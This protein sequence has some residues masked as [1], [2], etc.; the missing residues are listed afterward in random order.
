MEKLD[1]LFIAIF[2]RYRR[3][4]GDASIEQAWRRAL[5]SATGY[6]IFPVAVPVVLLMALVNASLQIG[7]HSEHRKVVQIVA[8]VIGISIIY[9]MERRFRRFLTAPPKLAVQES[10][11]ERN[12][13]WLARLSSAVCLIAIGAL[14]Y[15]IRHSGSH[16]LDGY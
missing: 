4:M 3:K 11:P 13:I 10:I 7:T 2:S 15:A 14:G 16:F 8:V 9:G 6:F 5:N 1:E 12:V